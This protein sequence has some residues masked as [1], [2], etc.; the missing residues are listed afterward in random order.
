[1]AL[2]NTLTVD[3]TAN[4]VVLNA[5]VATNLVDQ[6]TYSQ[7]ANTV[8]FAIRPAITISGND[9]ITLIEQFKLFQAAILTNFNPPQFATIPFTGVVTNETYVSFINQWELQ[10]NV[11]GSGNFVSN[12]ATFSTFMVSLNNRTVSQTLNFSE[13]MLV[14]P[15]FIHYQTS[16]FN[17][18]GV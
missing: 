10:I 6:L 1:M 14:L 3:L 18:F 5:M 8:T 13:W 4:S 11:G 7:S 2:V 12:S 17:F 15:A 9:F 16:V